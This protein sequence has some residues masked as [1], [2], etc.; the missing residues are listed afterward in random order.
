ML[1]NPRSI[2]GN[3]YEII[4]KIGSGGMAVV[5]RGKD[6]KLDRYV[7]I[8]VLREEFIGDE[9]FLDR[10]ESE[11]RSVAKLSHPNI[12]RVYDV[13]Q[14][15]DISYIVMEYIHGNTL[16]KA[17]RE[18]AP[19]DSR[20][21]LNVAIQIASALV[22][23]H[24]NHIVHRDIKPQNILV[25][26]DG[27][28]KVT[29]FGIARTATVSTVTT[30]ANAAGSVHYFSP[31]QARGGYV[32]EKSDIYSLG[33]TMYEMITGVLPFQGTNSVAIALKH[34][35]EEVPDI[36][37]HNPNCTKA[38]Q[39][40]IAK[41]VMKKSDERYA[42]INLMLDDLIRARNQNEIMDELE[43]V[44]NIEPTNIAITMNDMS[45]KHQRRR[46]MGETTR[47][48]RTK[49]PPEEIK[50]EVLDDEKL[51]ETRK[52]LRH[53]EEEELQGAT[54]FR[55][56]D[57]VLELQS[58]RAMSEEYRPKREREETVAPEIPFS[59]QDYEE[60]VDDEEDDDE[61]EIPTRPQR[62]LLQE[63]K[64]NIDRNIERYDQK[65][66]ISKDEM[67]EEEYVD[68]PNQET[69]NRQATRERQD[70][71]RRRGGNAPMNS[72]NQNRSSQSRPPQN[73]NRM[74]KP[75]LTPKQKK[76]QSAVVVIAI[77]TS[78]II[79]AGISIAAIRTFNSGRFD[80]TEEQII[81]EVPNLVGLTLDD[82]RPPVEEI[83]LFIEVVGEERHPTQD[84]GVIIDQVIEPGTILDAGESIGVKIS[85]G[86]QSFSMPN[87]IG[88]TEDEANETLAEVIGI[89][90]FPTYAF[91]DDVPIGEI[92]EQFPAEKENITAKSAIKVTVSR[93]ERSTSVVVPNLV[94]RTLSEAK[95]DLKV[96]GLYT[97]TVTGVAPDSSDDV[98]VNSSGTSDSS[99][100]LEVDDG[101]IV[102]KQS[103]SSGTSV[104]LGS[105][106][107]LEVIMQP[108]VTV[109]EPSEDDEEEEGD[110]EENYDDLLPEDFFTDDMPEGVLPVYPTDEDGNTIFPS[111]DDES[112]NQNDAENT[113][114]TDTNTNT[115]TEE[116]PEEVAPVP[117]VPEVAGVTEKTFTISLPG[118]VTG[119]IYVRMSREDLDG[120]Y[121]VVDEF[122]KAE[123]FPYV[124]T[125]KGRG[126][127]TVSCYLN[128]R[129][130]WSEEVIYQN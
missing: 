129:L 28:V 124:V 49:T 81:L 53:D 109:T 98:S 94:G 43:E 47:N 128:E 77:L 130:Q 56:E 13:G 100:V 108:K 40:I 41:A 23:A 97:G 72:N 52:E 8:K 126:A 87:L 59:L 38:L 7:S 93:G 89:T 24:K 112:E 101:S 42:N 104:A 110:D 123:D 111:T 96:L 127:A 30:T 3:R 80:V 46:E 2:L 85:N 90:P 67:Y 99:I 78:L 35:N 4:D 116:V 68:L 119:D 19:F 25:S 11:A 91:S 84:R 1:L 120:F 34:I 113:G 12:V 21:T 102:L 33:I 105:S 125:V 114:D 44:P 17:I 115:D 60:D 95:N 106:I 6:K 9:D 37:L 69:R 64:G 75:R 31:E 22:Q 71:Q 55:D 66:N 26:T 103:V 118:E 73:R 86:L 70:T 39:G 57:D 18:K 62:G 121:V 88:L 117:V 122:R 65:L 74:A 48:S 82:A 45:T 79:M 20:S 36:R 10:F 51:F 15:G 76:Q 16:K 58:L 61:E 14:E 32:D 83:G 5:Y 54:R 29:D 50:M 27:V 92:F 63:F 107:A